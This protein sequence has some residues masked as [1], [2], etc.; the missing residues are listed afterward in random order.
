MAAN[1]GCGAIEALP[2]VEAWNIN[3]GANVMYLFF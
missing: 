3:A 1:N 2:G